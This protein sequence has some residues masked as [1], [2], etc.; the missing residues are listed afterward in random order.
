MPASDLRVP[1]ATSRPSSD[2]RHGR[3]ALAALGLFVLAMVVMGRAIDVE[4]HV[5]TAQSW[6][7]ALGVLA[8]AAYVCVY[9]AATLIGVPGL[10]FTVLAPILFGPLPGFVVMVIASALSAA[11]GFL[12]ARFL[13][14]DL[15]AR[16]LDGSGGFARLAALV[17]A[18]HWMVIPLVRIVPIAPFVV[19]NYGFGL[20]GI[21]FRRYF[22]WTELAM[23]PMNAVLVFGTDVLYRASTGG[24]PARP[25][26]VAALAAAGALG[27]LA[28]F[29]R[30]AAA[31]P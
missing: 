8:P 21:A 4:H 16:R 27:A 19:V 25:L 11:L 31:R 28:L 15:V 1:G 29:G 26:L 5:E 24:A 2:R 10:P 20:T 3:W 7:G 30:K 6:A 17:E 14:R 9:T 23:V 13:A 22:L 18:H 12:T